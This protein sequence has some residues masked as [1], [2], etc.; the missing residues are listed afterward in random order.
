MPTTIDDDRML[1][2]RD[3]EVEVT[4]DNAHRPVMWVNVN[5]VCRLRITNLKR[6][7]VDGMQLYT[8][9]E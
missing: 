6:L 1:D 7:T 5:G 3:A 4:F 2:Y 8:I 9:E